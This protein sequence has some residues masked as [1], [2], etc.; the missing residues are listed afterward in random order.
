VKRLTA[1]LSIVVLASAAAAAVFERFM[2][3]D[4]PEDRAILAY[5]ALDTSGAA[6]AR[7]LAEMGI[8]L[9]NRGFADDAERYL[10]RAVKLDKKDVEVRYRLGLVL[11]RQGKY[12]QAIRQYSKVVDQRP[13]YAY[14][15]FMLALAEERAGHRERAAFHYAKAYKH[16]P[17]LADPTRNPLVL[18]SALQ[19]EAQLLRYRREVES[20]T[21][22]VGAI[23]PEAVRTMMAGRPDTPPPAIPTPEAI[24]LPTPAPTPAPAPPPVAGPA[25]GAR[26]R[27][28]VEPGRPAAAATPAPT[29]PPLP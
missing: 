9:L 22:Q 3:P 17:E 27:P 10:E 12:R 1:V 28:A 13:G 6:T 8:L 16:A 20:D 24:A 5:Q 18:D 4:R 15:R 7:D 23:D 19:V 11:Q 29:P 21:I 14:A 25:F 26:Q 2:S